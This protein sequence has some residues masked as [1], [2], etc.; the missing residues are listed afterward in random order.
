MNWYDTILSIA[1]AV[2]ACVWAG[3]KHPDPWQDL[4]YILLSCLG[5]IIIFLRNIYEA[6]REKHK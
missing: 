1:F 5:V 4:Y 3:G 2:S 6:I